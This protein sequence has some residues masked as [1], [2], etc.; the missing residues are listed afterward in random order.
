LPH[1]PDAITDAKSAVV[2]QARKA[3]KR[4]IREQVAPGPKDK[5]R[6]GPGYE[7]LLIQWAD[8]WRVDVA[9]ERSASL[10]KTRLALDRVWADYAKYLAGGG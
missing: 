4:S 3:T 10:R 2:E 7:Q 6:V 9:L 8:K 5:R 1:D